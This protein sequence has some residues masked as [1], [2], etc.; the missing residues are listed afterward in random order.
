MTTSRDIGGRI[1]DF[2]LIAVAGGGARTVTKLSTPLRQ[3]G[4]TDAT[5]HPTRGLTPVLAVY[6]ARPRRTMPKKPEE[7]A[8]GPSAETLLL[9]VLA[10]VLV[11]GLL[12][13]CAP[14]GTGA[15]AAPSSLEPGHPR[16]SGLTSTSTSSSP[17][18][19]P[20][21]P[22]TAPT[23][24]E[25]DLS[26]PSFGVD[27]RRWPGTLDAARSLL[28][29][30]P[31]ELGGTRRHLY[32]TPGD[33]V[34]P[35]RDAGV[36]YGSVGSLAVY[37]EYRTT[38]TVDGKPEMA[39]ANNQLSAAFGLVFACTKG[40]YRGTAP[41]PSYP[42]GGPGVTNKPLTTDVWFSCTIDGAEGQDDFT[43]QAVGWTSRKTAW[44]VIADS[45]PTAR[46]IVK[47]LAR[48]GS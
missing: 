20:G 14:T 7:K 47:A 42:Q 26:G 22:T 43:G 37:E 41:R 1:L 45:Q 29:A 8:R 32:Y 44:L 10:L 11:V 24:P 13:G 48:A 16:P 38:D 39:S 36:V 12:T 17:S 4:F 25:L 3:V 21:T 35:S 34:E 15:A 33:A 28:S 23:G 19:G 46:T 5:T 2:I 30:M 18:A 31:K 40:S 9:P 6:L 27:G